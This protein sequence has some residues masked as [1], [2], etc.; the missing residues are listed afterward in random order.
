MI[1][2]GYMNFIKNIITWYRYII[3]LDAFLSFYTNNHD[4][5]MSGVVW[6]PCTL[7]ILNSKSVVLNKACVHKVLSHCDP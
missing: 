3:C 7:G 6:T 5:Y 2:S 4:I 1:Q